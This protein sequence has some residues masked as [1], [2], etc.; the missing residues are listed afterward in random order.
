[1]MHILYLFLCSHWKETQNTKIS[2][3]NEVVMAAVTSSVMRLFR[4]LRRGGCFGDFQE[5]YK[6]TAHQKVFKLP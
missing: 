3:H 5:S 1:M 2:K 4:S 6:Y